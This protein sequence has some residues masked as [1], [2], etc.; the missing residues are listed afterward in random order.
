MK[1]IPE[2]LKK[3]I[4]TLC[5]KI[6]AYGDTEGLI[7]AFVYDGGGWDGLE[8]SEFRTKD[9]HNIELPENLETFFN[10]IMQEA[11]D[12]VGVDIHGADVILEVDAKNKKLS[13]H[14]DHRVFKEYPHQLKITYD[15]LKEYMPDFDDIIK[16]YEDIGPH[17]ETTYEGG[18]DSGWIESNMVGDKGD[19]LINNKL[20]E[21]CYDFLSNNFGAW[22]DNEGS[23]GRIILNT[24]KKQI[25][26]NHIEYIEGTESEKNIIEF[27]IS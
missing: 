24:E 20:E 16:E 1:K 6:L 21:L 8:Y 4:K 25:I 5:Y 13:V 17:I 26:I 27:D 12:K 7:D 19:L 2:H 18:G 14:M 3:N 9:G 15:K 10:E 23:R 22:G 11:F